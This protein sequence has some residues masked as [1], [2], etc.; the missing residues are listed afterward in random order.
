MREGV[1][2]DYREFR[3]ELEGNPRLAR[4]SA[5]IGRVHAGAGLRL[6]PYATLR[7]DGEHI[8]LGSEVEFAERATVHI[9]D[10][11]LPAVIGDRVSVGRYA[12]VHACT[13]HEGCVV[14]DCAVVMDGAE[15]GPYAVIAAGALVPPRKRLAGGWLYSGAPAEP[16]REV[17]RAEVERLRVALRSGAGDGLVCA[18][19][20]PPLDMSPYAQGQE[21]GGHVLGVAGR[22]PRI[23]EHAYAA[24]TALL[25]GD[26][27]LAR[28]ASVWFA[29]AVYAG[30]G[31]IEIGARSNI[32][33]NSLL[34]TDARR[35]SILIAEDVTVGHN[36]RMGAC[37]VEPDCLIGMGC[38]IGDGCVVERGACVGARAILEPGTRVE[39]GWIWAGR[40]ARAFRPL[41]PEEAE[42]FRVGRRVYVGYARTYLEAG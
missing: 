15:I 1:L 30:D 6:A 4:D 25:A 16:V 28:E 23:E 40:P 13:M 42:A 9:A 19:A 17:D 36:V 7:A 18:S 26:V 12:L 38:E 27:R 35:G 34:E 20:L 21:G 22:F 32:Q 37:V 5:V 39:A 3:P 10:S 11:V 24:P 33:D 2:L 31:R 14:G 29:C 8:R 41:K